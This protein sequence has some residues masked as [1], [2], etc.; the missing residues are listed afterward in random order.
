M[1]VAV[2]IT[3]FN[4]GAY[5]QQAV[6]SVLEQTSADEIDKVIIVDD[7]SAPSTLDVLLALPKLDSRIRLILE[8]G[9]G[10]AKNRNIAISKT[11]SEYIAILDGDDFWAPDKLERQLNLLRSDETIGLA[12]AAPILFEDEAPWKRT[13]VVVRDLRYARD[14]TLDYFIHDAPIV[15]SSV[16]MRRAAFEAIGG[17]DDSIRVF[18]DT[19]FYLRLSRLYRLAAVPGPLLYKRV[20]ASALTAKRDKLMMHHA[21][22]ALHFAA[23]E[24]RLLSYVGKR[25]AER[26]RKL[27]NLEARD[28]S[29]DKARDFYSLALSLNPFNFTARASKLLLR[30]YGRRSA[31]VLSARWLAH[32]FHGR[33]A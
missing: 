27:G 28:G 15:P 11:D 6:R 21:Y 30:C 31:S 8:R 1:S 10:L 7:G 4:E 32:L 25:L 23:E 12:Y 20:H 2:V 18:E 13:V 16:L 17:F 22:V 3:C 9:N 33:R 19:E 14:P 29:I 26:A 5:I 24:P